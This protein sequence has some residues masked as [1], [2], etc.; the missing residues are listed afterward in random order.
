MVRLDCR[1]FFLRKALFG[2][3]IFLLGAG[4]ATIIGAVSNR[5]DLMDGHS[6]FSRLGQLG[7]VIRSVGAMHLRSSEWKVGR[8]H[9]LIT[10]P[11]LASSESELADVIASIIIDGK[12]SSPF[13]LRNIDSKTPLP[14]IDFYRDFRLAN[15]NG[16]NIAAGLKDE[17]GLILWMLSRID[18]HR[19]LPGYDVFLTSFGCPANDTVREFL[20]DQWRYELAKE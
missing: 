2:L 13:L 17:Q 18:P 20:V 8:L 1:Q 7:F 11:S 6:F 14:D 16:P 4:F 9:T 3:V 5:A 10:D 12:S 15:L 19:L